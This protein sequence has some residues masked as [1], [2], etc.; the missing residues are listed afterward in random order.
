[1]YKK[2]LNNNSLLNSY[3]QTL[4]MQSLILAYVLSRNLNYSCFLE[5]TKHVPIIFLFVLFNK[6]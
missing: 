5:N 4:K 1:M 2:E 6:F 3:L